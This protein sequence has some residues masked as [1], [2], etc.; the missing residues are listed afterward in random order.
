[1]SR[2][3]YLNRRSKEYIGGPAYTFS[4]FSGPLWWSPTSGLIYTLRIKS[5]WHLLLASNF[6][7]VWTSG[8]CNS[9]WV[10]SVT[11]ISCDNFKR[12]SPWSP[13]HLVY[14]SVPGDPNNPQKSRIQ[15]TIQITSEDNKNPGML[16]LKNCVS[17]CRVV[18]SCPP[19][20]LISE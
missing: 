12:S 19:T 15:R 18:T 1:M 16:F 10:P 2:E 5:S 14:A 4:V 7:F 8:L 6:P 9:L 20:Y 17:T 11:A 3:F 13:S